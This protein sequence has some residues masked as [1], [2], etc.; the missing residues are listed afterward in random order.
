MLVDND[1]YEAASNVHDLLVK[2]H[3][4]D[5]DKIE[6]TRRLISEH[7]DIDAVLARFA[8]SSQAPGPHTTAPRSAVTTIRNLGSRIRGLTS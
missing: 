7:I 4:A 1:T 8:D 6:L 3:P 2:T 5:R